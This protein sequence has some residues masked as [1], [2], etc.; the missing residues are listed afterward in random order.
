[1]SSKITKG[2]RVQA[3]FVV[4]AT[5]HVSSSVLTGTVAGVCGDGRESR[6][7]T[8]PLVLSRESDLLPDLLS[9]NITKLQIGK[10]ENRFKLTSLPQDFHC[11]DL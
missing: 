6:G 8:F 9:H 3:D 1:M 11:N 7:T 4:L 5:K 2:I 10:A